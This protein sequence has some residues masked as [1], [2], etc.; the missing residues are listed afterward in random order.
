MHNLQG[1]LSLILSFTTPN[2]PTLP[3]HRFSAP[4]QN[5]HIYQITTTFQGELATI[6]PFTQR[7]YLFLLARSA[8]LIYPHHH[9]QVLKASSDSCTVHN[10]LQNKS[11]PFLFF[12]NSDSTFDITGTPCFPVQWGVA[13]QFQTQTHCLMFAEHLSSHPSWYM[14]SPEPLYSLVDHITCYLLCIFYFTYL[15]WGNKLEKIDF[16]QRNVYWQW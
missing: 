9:L 16:E 7:L 12:V 14:M 15:L 11:T 4:T 6:L 2:Y 8:E 5:K 10:P 3:S 13:I 1:S